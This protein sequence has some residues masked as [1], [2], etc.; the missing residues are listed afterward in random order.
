M[1]NLKKLTRGQMMKVIGSEANRD[2]CRCG[3][4]ITTSHTDTPQQCWEFCACAC[5]R[6]TCKESMA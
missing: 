2:H 1:R 3:C 5:K 6:S 4:G